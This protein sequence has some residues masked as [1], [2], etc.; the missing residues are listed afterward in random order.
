M[1][2]YTYFTLLALFMAEFLRFYVFV[3]FTSYQAGK[4]KLLFL[5]NQRW[6]CSSSLWFLLCSW[7]MIGFLRALLI[8]RSSLTLH[9]ETHTGSQ[10]QSVC[11]VCV[12]GFSTC[13]VGD[14]TDVVGRSSVC[15]SLIRAKCSHGQLP[16]SR[17][18][19]LVSAFP[20]VLELQRQNSG[21]CWR[22]RGFLHPQPLPLR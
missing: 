4:W 7:V 22:E 11:L 19:F 2:G 14:A 16:S 6:H 3:F 1:Y 13:S 17:A 20:S 18:P 5:F 15:Y 10:L 12:Y 8:C 9:R 21:G